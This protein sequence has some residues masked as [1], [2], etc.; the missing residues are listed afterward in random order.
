VG[1][2]DAEAL[3]WMKPT[4][5]LVN[6]ARGPIV[7]EPALL[8]A[9]SN[10]RL[11]GATLD[12]YAEEPLPV[13][14]PLRRLPNVL[15]TPHVGYVS[16]QNYRQFYQQ[17][18][19]DIQAWAAGHAPFACSADAPNSAHAHCGDEAPAPETPL[20]RGASP[21][22]GPSALATHCPRIARRPHR[23][24]TSHIVTSFFVLQN[25]H[26]NPTVFRICPRLKLDGS[27]QKTKAPQKIE[28]FKL[29]RRSGLG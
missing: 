27:V 6:T 13:D 5:R 7:D 16:E 15:A 29:C 19:A 22:T 4:A 2:V 26:I 18:I 14:H 24:P 20:K 17:M 11:A 28:T 10:G 23:V 25:F 1:W 3:G 8:E 21:P 12:V 9:L